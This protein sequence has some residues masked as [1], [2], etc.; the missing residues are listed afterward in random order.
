[1]NALPGQGDTLTELL[2]SAV[3]D[4]G[5]A[6]NPSCVFFLVTR[7]ASH[8]DVVHVT[9]GWV[10]KE[11]HAENFSREVSRAFTAKV[12]ALVSDAQYGDDVPAGGKFPR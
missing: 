3:S 9:E 12:G 8:R 1:M 7:S 4:G 6:S 2:L 10:S 11:A 5:P